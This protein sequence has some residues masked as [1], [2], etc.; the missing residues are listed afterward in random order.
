[1]NV[2]GE[3]PFAAPPVANT[4]PSSV[5]LVKSAFSMPEPDVKTVPSPTLAPR[6]ET[7]PCAPVN[8][9]RLKS[10]R[11]MTVLS[12]TAELIDAYA[13]CES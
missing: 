11:V 1:M 2:G 13:S 7:W 10:S 9:A 5:A 12:N 4:T 3:P 6:N 8:L